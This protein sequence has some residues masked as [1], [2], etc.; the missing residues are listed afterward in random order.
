MHLPHLPGP[1]PSHPIW[2]Q[3]RHLES[4]LWEPVGQS[5]ASVDRDIYGTRVKQLGPVVHFI[6]STWR[7]MSHTCCTPC[8]AVGHLRPL[9]KSSE[10]R[11]RRSIGATFL[12]RRSEPRKAARNGR[13]RM[14]TDRR[15]S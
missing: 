14:L 12:F 13:R 2:F 9:L 7:T 5:S 3:A 6:G 1:S 4:S 11:A 10:A 15:H 8:I